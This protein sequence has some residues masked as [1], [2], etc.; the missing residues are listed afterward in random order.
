[1]ILRFTMYFFDVGFDQRIDFSVDKKAYDRKKRLM[2]V[3]LGVDNPT[4]FQRNN[5]IDDCISRIL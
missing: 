1:M 2:L 4:I 5:K 3:P